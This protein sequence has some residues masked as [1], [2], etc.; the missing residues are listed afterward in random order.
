M[1]W[2]DWMEVGYCSQLFCNKH[3]LTIEN[4]EI[5]SF[6]GN[7]PSII[8]SANFLTYVQKMCFICST[9]TM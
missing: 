4:W 7:P 3:C 9:H 1:S 8:L 6:A 5:K 2:E